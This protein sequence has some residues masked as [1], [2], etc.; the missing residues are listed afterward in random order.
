MQQPPSDSSPAPSIHLPRLGLRHVPG[1]CE[2]TALAVELNS[3]GRIGCESKLSGLGSQSSDEV[4]HGIAIVE[5]RD[6][7]CSIG[8]ILPEARFEDGMV[9][10]FG[11]GKAIALLEGWVDIQ[12]A[13]VL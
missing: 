8:L 10:Q 7:E 6:D 2:D 1:H 4:S 5:L 11:A 13:A 12:K 3:A 9:D